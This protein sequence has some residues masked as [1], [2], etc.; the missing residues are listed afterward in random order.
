MKFDNLNLIVGLLHFHHNIKDKPIAEIVP[1]D[2]L[3]LHKC[4]LL[5]SP[6][7]DYPLVGSILR[8]HHI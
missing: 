5:L 3:I 7:Q 8:I 2:K 6:V 4:L 1:F